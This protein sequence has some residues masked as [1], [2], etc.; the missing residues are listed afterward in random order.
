MYEQS[1]DAATL[2]TQ[3]ETAV[4]Y[5]TITQPTRIEWRRDATLAPDLHPIRNAFIGAVNVMVIVAAALWSA[6]VTSW[7]AW[8]LLFALCIAGVAFLMFFVAL[9]WGQVQLGIREYSSETPVVP[10]TGRTLRIMA[11]DPD[12][13]RN[14]TVARYAM[15]DGE[16]TRLATAL[17]LNGWKMDRDTIR[18]AGVIPSGD[19]VRWSEVVLPEFVKAGLIDEQ[20]QVTRRGRALFEPYVNAPAPARFEASYNP[21][22]VRRQSTGD[23]RGDSGRRGGGS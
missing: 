14:H 4:N 7:A 18:A 1:I 21:P 20:R 2:R 9:L 16:L 6:T 5:P 10:E 17:A 12:N 23:A 22:P 13:P 11:A 15:S 19:M 8:A 3:R